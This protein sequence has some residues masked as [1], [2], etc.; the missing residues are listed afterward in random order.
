MTSIVSP[1]GREHLGAPARGERLSPLGLASL[2]LTAA[3]AV[4]WVILQPATA[5][6]AAQVYRTELYQRSGWSLV[7][8]G[9][10]GGHSLLAYSLLTPQ[11]MATLGVG[12]SGLLAATVTSVAFSRIARSV[13]PDR[14]VWAT[15]WVAWAATADLL[16][17]RVTY[18]TG[19]AFAVLAVLALLRRR[20]PVACLLAALAAAASPVAGVFLG[21]AA[22]VWW[23]VERRPGALAMAASA[24]GV[25]LAVVLLFGDGGSQPYGAS[26]AIAVSVA[27][28]L[29]LVVSR[30]ERL[31]RCALG[32]YAAAVGASWALP[33]AMGSNVARLGVAFAV[34]VMLLS[35]RRLPAPV[36]GMVVAVAGAWL[37]FAPVTEVRKTVDAPEAGAAFYRPLLA[38]LRRRGASGERIEV[39]PSATRWEAVQVPPQQPLA[40]GWAT[41]IDRARNPLFYAPGLTQEHYVQ[42]LRENAVSY[43]ALSATPRERWGQEEEALLERGVAGLRRV[44]SSGDWRLYAVVASEPLAGGARVSLMRGNE[45]RLEAKRRGTVV[46]RVRWS[47]FWAAGPGACVRRRDD[48]F[49]D[50]VVRRPGAV[51]LTASPLA[52]TS[53]GTRCALVATAR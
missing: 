12:A 35:R 42:W 24:A 50:V 29:W 17:G 26:A 39:V 27:A 28:G 21:F 33:T 11:L 5:D 52:L 3:L 47:R 2:A 15:A 53:R 8:T 19:Q 46:L 7:D 36:V 34:P 44:W 1:V 6:L 51:T 40:R 20:Q 41:Q 32:A 16:V 13:R 37:V 45:I 25:T 30:E 9:W 22:M 49:M 18:A 14:W 10:F 43:V 31:A 48:G 23:W 4:T 38:E